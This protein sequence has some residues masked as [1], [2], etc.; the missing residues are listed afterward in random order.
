MRGVHLCG[1]AASLLCL[2]S[3]MHAGSPEGPSS[4]AKD[5][6][7]AVEILT[8]DTAGIAVVGASVTID[9]A[10]AGTTPYEGRLA[11][12]MH[13]VLVQSAGAR[14]NERKVR[15]VDGGRL[16]LRFDLARIRKEAVSPP[17]GH[18][19]VPAAI[20]KTIKSHLL[21][22]GRCYEA[23]QSK[24]PGLHGEV[25]MHFRISGDGRVRGA[26]VKISTMGAP[27]AEA[28]IEKTFLT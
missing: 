26:W 23:G 17:Q 21:E 13:D 16:L 14:V 18:G 2:A 27:E 9:G 10:R 12:G 1:A 28:C 24:R 4:P 15:V 8:V 6:S 20:E 11:P 19:R 25:V 22:I 7:A 5:L 3:C